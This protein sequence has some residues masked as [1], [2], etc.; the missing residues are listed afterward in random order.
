MKAYPHELSGG[1]RQRVMIAIALSGRPRLLLADEPTTALDVTIQDQILVL[2]REIRDETGMSIVLV[3]HDMG[4][5]A[6]TCDRVAVMYAGHIVEV[7]TGR[8]PVRAAA[9]I[10]T[11]RRCSR[12]C[13]ASTAARPAASCE[14]IPGQPP[15]VRELPG[16]CPFAPRCAHAREGCESVSMELEHVR[17]RPRHRVSVRAVGGRVDSLG[18]RSGAGAVSAPLLTVHELSKWF[19]MRRSVGE[20]AR[21]VPPQRLVAV[22]RVSLELAPREVLGIVGESGSG[23]TT[24]ARCLNRLHEPS[25][26]SIVFDGTDVRT[27]GRDELRAVRRR[28]QMV[29]QD[30]YTSLNPRLTVADA[31][32]EAGRVHGR[33]TKETGARVR[34][35]AARDGRAR[36]SG[37]P[38]G[39][40]GSSRA[41]SGSA[42]RSRAPLQSRRTSSSA[43]KRCRA[44]TSRCRRRS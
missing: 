12:R 22:D 5:I 1:M 19:P 10:R 23:K 29:F 37:S 8:R 35:R 44:S 18:N 40:R 25:E 3:S 36:R 34:R 15:D 20:W 2:L 21:R 43:T 28:M 27:A 24:L 7:A 33:T 41:V 9:S 14:A 38:T 39:A 31:I 13:R 4:V 11:R 17:A 42:S 16:G 26:G 6:Q 30:P 32:L